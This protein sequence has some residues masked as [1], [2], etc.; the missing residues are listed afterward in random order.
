[1]EPVNLF[2]LAAQQAQWLAVRQSAVAG[3]IANANTPGYLAQDVE[4]FESL[5]AGKREGLR[6]THPMHVTNASAAEAYAVETV[7]NGNAVMPSGNSVVLEQEML[8]SGEV[9]RSYELNTAIV[10]SFHRMFMMTTRS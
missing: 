4:P 9:R 5:V 8:K 10:K 3:N 7:E 6:A 1:M 2:K